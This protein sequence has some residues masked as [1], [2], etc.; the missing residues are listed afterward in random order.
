MAGFAIF[1]LFFLIRSVKILIQPKFGNVEVSTNML[2]TSAWISQIEIPFPFL[3]EDDVHVQISFNQWWIESAKALFCVFFLF[4]SFLFYFIFCIFKKALATN[5]NFFLFSEVSVVM[6][7]N[8]YLLFYF[9]VL[10]S[11]LKMYA[12]WRL[13]SLV[14]NMLNSVLYPVHV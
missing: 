7:G 6:P 13:C 10:I 8:S 14:L 12:L 2:I 1:S 11:I 4:F 3:L 5:L 9:K